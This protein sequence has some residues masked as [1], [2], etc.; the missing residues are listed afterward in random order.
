M[1]H[2]EPTPVSGV[3]G[4]EEHPTVAMGSVQDG[5]TEI[6]APTPAWNPPPPTEHP[7]MQHPSPAPIRQSHYT[8]QAPTALTP[9]PRAPM[10]P[11]PVAPA[12][13]AYRPAAPPAPVAPVS[14]A[15]ASV[16][17]MAQ[18]P[19][20]PSRPR[21][22]MA[23]PANPS[24]EPKD[25][26]GAGW[27]AAIA[28]DVVLVIVAVVMAVSTF[29]GSSDNAAA[30]SGAGAVSSPAPS[31]SAG[32]DTTVQKSFAS[33]S[34]N[35]TCDM[36]EAAVTCVIRTV[37]V[38]ADQQCEGALAYQVVLQAGKVQ[39]ACLTSTDSAKI[40]VATT[41]T[42]LEYDQSEQV[43]SFTCTSTKA[44]VSCTD[45]TATV[46]MSRSGIRQS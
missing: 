44:D 20:P 1:S 46:S 14:V 30:N 45:G 18:H 2:T 25:R 43:G 9:P 13:A 15:P 6:F 29:G 38:P 40:P 22:A 3:P 36:A 16:Q 12:P 19:A 26:L 4:H 23:E 34:Q 11:A 10:P 33:P 5:G 37:S 17:P 35:I 41:L 28:A 39:T 21:A 42:T 8:Q 24:R 31:A 32:A 27:I 7:T